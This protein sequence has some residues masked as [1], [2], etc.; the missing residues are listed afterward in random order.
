MLSTLSDNCIP[1]SR[2]YFC[3]HLYLLKNWKTLI[4]LFAAELE[5]PKIGKSGKGIIDDFQWLRC[6]VSSSCTLVCLCSSLAIHGRYW[7]IMMIKYETNKQDCEEKNRKTSSVMT[8]GSFCRRW[9]FLSITPAE[10]LISKQVISV[11]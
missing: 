11:N 8:H 10:K 5:D 2:P 7:I 1:I 6:A 3:H 9:S 4:F